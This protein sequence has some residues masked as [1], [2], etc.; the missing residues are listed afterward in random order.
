MI[1]GSLICELAQTDLALKAEAK[2]LKDAL[3]REQ[4]GKSNSAGGGL[5]PGAQDPDDSMGSIASYIASRQGDVKAL[6]EGI[7]PEIVKTMQ[8]LVDFVLEGGESGKGRPAPKKEEMEMVIPA[9]ALQQLAL[10][11]LVLGYRLREAEAKGDYRKL[12]E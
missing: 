2:A 5:I 8:M 3:R 4:G 11:Q 12:L 1:N 6:T 9:P 7:S 10:W